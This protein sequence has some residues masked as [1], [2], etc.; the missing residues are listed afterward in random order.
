MPIKLPGDANTWRS[1]CICFSH[2]ITME[3]MW[4]CFIGYQKWYWSARVQ[5]GWII[6]VR[7]C[8]FRILIH[9]FILL[10]LIA[11]SLDNVNESISMTHRGVL[12]VTMLHY[13]DN[14]SKA[15]MLSPLY[16]S[17][18]SSGVF[19]GLGHSAMAAYWVKFKIFLCNLLRHYLV[20]W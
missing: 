4:P 16:Y 12:A 2:Q 20:A 7:V 15:T 10:R 8:I 3:S 19:T 11:S 17:L 14:H 6:I 1:Q 5:F 13:C 9:C 18:C